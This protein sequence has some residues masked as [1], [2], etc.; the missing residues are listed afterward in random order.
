MPRQAKP[1]VTVAV[2]NL[3]TVKAPACYL[4]TVPWQKA[5][6]RLPLTALIHIV[7]MVLP[8]A[9]VPIHIVLIVFHLTPWWLSCL[10]M[11]AFRMRKSPGKV[12]KQ[13]W[14]VQ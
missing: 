14:E 8:L 5:C 11:L 9:A 7:L 1:P 3:L 6:W 10:T 2:P 13:R 4:I 12:E